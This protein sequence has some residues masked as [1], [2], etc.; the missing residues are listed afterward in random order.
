MKREIG[1]YLIFGI[2]TTIIGVGG[3]ALLLGVGWHYVVA[4]TV[5]WLL[6]VLFAF[7]TNRKYVFAS[8]A[9]S[10]NDILREGTSFFMS[11]IGTWIMETAGL[12]LLIESIH[13]DQMISKY[14]MS[15]FVVVANYVLSKV[16]V[17]QSS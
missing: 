10:I 4:S 2:L 3:Y 7:I 16:F 1:L 6:A 17:F 9:I 13:L 11:R 15:V 12:L 5:S 8:N 14:I